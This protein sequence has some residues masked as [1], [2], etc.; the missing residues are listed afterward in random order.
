MYCTYRL[1][2]A[3]RRERRN[4]T[5]STHACRAVHC[6]D[7]Q[8]KSRHRADEEPARSQ[9]A[10][11]ESRPPTAVQTAKSAPAQ[12]EEE[13]NSWNMTNLIKDQ[14]GEPYVKSFS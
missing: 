13:I 4:T 9:D 11:Q 5:T 10:A 3:R 14:Q 7:D 12:E 6:A 8:S 1:A 2:A